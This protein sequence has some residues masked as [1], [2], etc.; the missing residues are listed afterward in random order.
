KEKIKKKRCM[1]DLL[2]NI[3]KE[4]FSRKLALTLLETRTIDYSNEKIEQQILAF[5]NNIEKEG[6]NEAQG[7]E[8]IKDKDI[9]EVRQEDSLE[10]KDEKVYFTIWN[11]PNRIF[12]KQVTEI[13]K[14]FGQPR[15][16]HIL[17]SMNNKMRAEVEN[18]QLARITAGRSERIKLE[19]RH[20]IHAR[21]RNLSKFMKKVLLLRQLR[22]VNAKAV[23]IFQNKNGNPRSQVVVEF[24]IEEDKERDLERKL[25]YFNYAIEWEHTMPYRK[26]S[27]NM[28]ISH[29]V[30]TRRPLATQYNQVSQV[31]KDNHNRKEWQKEKKTRKK[32]KTT[33]APNKRVNN[34][35]E[36]D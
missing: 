24:E 2:E 25:K 8:D 28:I 7:A 22:G 32:E 29:V 36:I 16:I 6:Q 18:G 35:E 26:G 17:H 15:E 19:K 30:T 34:K 14:K 23:H 1:P 9:K 4:T 33:Q 5:L 11:L 3:A 10:L 20:Q 21:I 13:I 12:K 31:E 27:E